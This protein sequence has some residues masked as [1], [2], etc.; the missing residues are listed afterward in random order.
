[1][2]ATTTYSVIAAT[3]SPVAAAGMTYIVRTGRKSPKTG[4]ASPSLMVAVPTISTASCYQAMATIDG[5]TDDDCS[6]ALA[7]WVDDARAE[8]VKE[9]ITNGTTQ[10]SDAEVDLAAVIKW[11]ITKAVSNRLSK[12]SIDEW[13]N[14]S[15]LISNILA[16]NPALAAAPEAQQLQVLEV[17]KAKLQSLAAIGNGMKPDDAKKLLRYVVAC[18]E[19]NMAVKAA[20]IAKLNALSQE[21]IS[22]EGLLD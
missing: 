15:D 13:V 10:F 5:V 3:A 7:S 19:G 8:M 17:V 11:T 16:S 21:T 9:A 1:M 14:G 18:E 6:Q 2:N 20:L 12:A 22:L 4:T